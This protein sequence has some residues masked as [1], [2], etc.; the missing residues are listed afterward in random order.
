MIVSLEE[1]ILNTLLEEHP[2]IAFLPQ[3]K[4]QKIIQQTKMPVREY[5]FSLKN[6]ETAAN[7]ILNNQNKEVIIKENSIEIPLSSSITV[8][9]K[10]QEIKND[11]AKDKL[12]EH[13][14]LVDGFL[15]IEYF[16]E[17]SG[18]GELLKSYKENKLSLIEDFNLRLFRYTNLNQFTKQQEANIKT[19]QAKAIHSEDIDLNIIS[20]LNE[21]GFMK[22][23]EFSTLQDTEKIHLTYAYKKEK[24]KINII[25]IYIG[26][27]ANYPYTRLLQEKN[28][29]DNR[30]YRYN[31]IKGF[32]QEYIQTQQGFKNKIT[33]I[34]PTKN[35]ILNSNN[36]IKEKLEETTKK[37]HLYFEDQ[38]NLQKKINLFESYT[39]TKITKEEKINLFSCQ[40]PPIIRIKTAALYAY[41]DQ[42]NNQ[43]NLKKYI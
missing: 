38:H 12:K 41:L 27:G 4:K 19:N 40:I 2:E 23:E 21:K 28:Q 25:P 9:R 43:E 7:E 1:E 39:N 18:S 34:Q 30:F 14:I 16:E 8:R 6:I 22:K 36:I 42:I 33:Q 20:K 29:G 15:D 37:Y 3:T 11:E 24:N 35:Q 17:F 32:E 13:K 10:I 5:L 26:I 31:P